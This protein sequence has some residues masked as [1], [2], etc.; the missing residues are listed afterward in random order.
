MKRISE[1]S[2]VDKKNDLNGEHPL[3]TVYG[4]R[5]NAIDIYKKIASRYP[6]IKPHYIQDVGILESGEIQFK[7]STSI[8]DRQVVIL[9]AWLKH[10]YELK[11][12]ELR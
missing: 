2:Y 3:C 4:L 9:L 11:D 7:I 5:Q 8:K 12:E 1:L 10:H 6:D